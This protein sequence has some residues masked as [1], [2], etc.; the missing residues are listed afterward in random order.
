MARYRDK[1]GR[2][3]ARRLAVVLGAFLGV[4]AARAG[5]LAGVVPEQELVEPRPGLGHRPGGAARRGVVDEDALVDRDLFV[6]VAAPSSD[7][8]SSQML[9][10]S[11]MVSPVSSQTSSL[12][13]VGDAV[14]VAFRRAVQ[15]HGPGLRPPGAPEADVTA[16]EGAAL[17]EI[18]EG[19]LDS[20][21]GDPS[22]DADEGRE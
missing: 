14:L 12:I 7:R 2:A 13:A 15:A 6:L 11:P 8:L 17:A 10:G 3:P 21:S 22:A 16:V 19:A 1:G 20:F 5:G 4:A 18:V 9:F